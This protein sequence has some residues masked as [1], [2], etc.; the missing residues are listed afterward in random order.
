MSQKAILENRLLRLE[1]PVPKLF[2]KAARV[3]EGFSKL[4]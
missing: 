4:T 2:I 3:V 1:A